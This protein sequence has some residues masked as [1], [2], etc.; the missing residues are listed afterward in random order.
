[1]I[2]SS[3]SAANLAS[4]L[5]LSIVIEIFWEFDIPSPV[6]N[7]NNCSSNLLLKIYMNSDLY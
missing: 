1:M 7:Q 3:D 2:V 5:K 4:A 6:L